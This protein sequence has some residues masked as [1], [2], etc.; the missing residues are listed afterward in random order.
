MKC[1][2][3]RDLWSHK[4][5]LSTNPEWL[6]DKS[7]VVLALK[8]Q[9]I[10]QSVHSVG[11]MWGMHQTWWTIHKCGISCWQLLINWF[12]F[13]RKKP[14]TCKTKLSKFGQIC[15]LV[16]SSITKKQQQ[17]S[18][19]STPDMIGVNGLHQ[20]HLTL[21]STSDDDDMHIGFKANWAS[22]SWAPGPNLP[23]TTHWV[24]T[25]KT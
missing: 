13:C 7:C 3:G 4:W 9:E 17:Q 22:A 10:S 5:R 2:Y 8:R 1:P 18:S 20:V 11:K 24:W 23:W 19:S 16:H 12:I 25:T 15:W 6:K 14:S 21:H